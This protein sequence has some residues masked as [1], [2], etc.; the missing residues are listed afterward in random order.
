MGSSVKIHTGPYKGDMSALCLL[1]GPQQ[2]RDPFLLAG[3]G[4]QILFYDTC[5]FELLLSAHIFEGVRVHG[6]EVKGR[7]LGIWV[8]LQS[9]GFL[10]TFAVHGERI[11]KLY[12]LI[13]AYDISDIHHNKSQIK[14]NF[15]K[16][17]PRCK[18]WVLDVRFL[19]DISSRNEDCTDCL[20]AVGTSDNSVS[21]WSM[22]HNA[23]IYHV[24]CAERCLLYC[25]RF[26]GSNTHDLLIAA[27]TIF[28]EIVIWDLDIP[29]STTAYE[30]KFSRIH[31]YLE[32]SSHLVSIKERLKGH[33]GSIFR[34]AWSQDGKKIASVSDDR[35]VRVWNLEHWSLPLMNRQADMF[36]LASV[37]YG[38]TARIWDCHFDS[39][40][41]ITVGE[42]CTYRV[43]TIDGKPLAK[44]SAHLCVYDSAKAVLFTA[45]ADSSIKIHFLGKLT[46]VTNQV[47]SGEVLSS[48]YPSLESFP[49]KTQ[50]D[51]ILHNKE[52]QLDS[53]SEYVRCLSL[54]GESCLYV[55]TN[56]G[57]LKCVHFTQGGQ[58]TW[59]DVYRNLNSESIFC[60]DTTRLQNNLENSV[61][62]ISVEDW[63]VMGDCKGYVTVLC[64]SW[65]NKI[66]HERF[67]LRW[68]A[69]GERKLLGVFWSSCPGTSSVFTA[70]T[71]GGLSMWKIN[72]AMAKSSKDDQT[73]DRLSFSSRFRDGVTM[74]GPSLVIRY[75]SCFNARIVCLDMCPSQELLLCGDQR[76]NILVF[77]I[78]LKVVSESTKSS[79]LVSF[80]GA[81]GISAVA[82]I[83]VV[84]YESKEQIKICST[85]RDGCV[86]TFALAKSDAKLFC[87]RVEKVS[88]VTVVESCE[89]CNGITRGSTKRTIVAGF[90]AED[91]L[92]YDQQNDCEILRV[93][94]GGWRRPH[95]YLIGD[96]P[97]VQHC[98]VFV[99]DGIIHLLRRWFVTPNVPFPLLYLANRSSLLSSFLL[100]SQ[101]HGREVHSVNFISTDEVSTG[102]VPPTS[103][104]ATGAEDG[105]VRIMRF[106]EDSLDQFDVCQVLGE[107]VGGS[108]VREIVAVT[109]YTL[110]NRR[111][112]ADKDAILSAEPSYILISVGAKEVLTCWL[113]EWDETVREKTQTLSSRWLSMK[114]CMKRRKFKKISD[115]DLNTIGQV[116][117]QVTE[118]ALALEGVDADDYDDDDLRYLA[119]TSFSIF[120]PLTRLQT[121]FVATASSNAAVILHAYQ[122]CAGTW[123]EL[124]LLNY[125]KAPVLTLQHL[126]ISRCQGSG[127]CKIVLFSGATDGSIAL[128]DV[129]DVVSEYCHKLVKEGN[130]RM[131]RPPSGRGSQGGNR[132]KSSRHHLHDQKQPL[133][134]RDERTLIEAR[135]DDGH[136]HK[137]RLDCTDHSRERFQYSL[138]LKPELVLSGTHQSGVNSLSVS[139]VIGGQGSERIWVLISGG[140]DQAVHAAI[141][142][143]S[144][145]YHNPANPRTNMVCVSKILFSSAHSSAVKGVWTDGLFAFTTGWDQRLK[146]WKLEVSEQSCSLVECCRTVINVPEPSSIHATRLFG[147]NYRVAIVGRG[148][149]I[150]NVKES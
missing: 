85:G 108:S 49:L 19:K 101:F 118:N 58:G 137:E 112:P 139:P 2:D 124:C 130:A 122:I 35:S 20:L 138:I 1:P 64:G 123:M 119:V 142:K 39:K 41:L 26:W 62:S 71:S 12:D 73:S 5:S 133:D 98:F 107:H 94:C 32:G 105:V 146:V 53:K 127:F 109:K 104:I 87:L 67:Y 22:H 126:V 96:F 27:G 128:W 135:C 40:S 81:H 136:C 84:E 77:I 13:L 76:G 7:F 34:I 99:K 79:P 57:V 45:G 115:M 66:F 14:L 37:M 132:W 59:F 121:F 89:L 134:G 31:G 86:C 95:A 93:A 47:G 65:S 82:S 116:D 30:Y 23:Y 44:K 120:C 117:A 143:L 68:R 90:L 63:I 75:Q 25:L 97:E 46:L 36:A 148:L 48:N 145:V 16:T 9:S 28:N 6:I 61:D 92:I 51:S 21:L 38:H 114:R 88:A 106:N 91:F 18:H 100:Q 70:D 102:Q 131:F 144:Q 72:G 43:W 4:P 149:Q 29:H 54:V 60:L 10:T 42:D 3:T 147:G 140:D 52:G 141:F 78:P 110:C 74:F 129:T 33:E 83:S 150:F 50:D 111:C 103:W 80:K 11:V 55:A 17:L 125:H 69:E 56:R 8:S 113:L 15:S 24:E